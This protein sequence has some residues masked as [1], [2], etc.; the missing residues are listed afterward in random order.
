MLLVQVLVLSFYCKV[1]AG[2]P[3]SVEAASP[4]GMV[5]SLGGWLLLMLL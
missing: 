3:P 4:L 5:E 2:I 1:V